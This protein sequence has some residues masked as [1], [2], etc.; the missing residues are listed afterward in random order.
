MLTQDE[1]LFTGVGAGSDCVCTV[2]GRHP[3]CMY[4]HHSLNLEKDRSYHGYVQQ[5]IFV[6]SL[7]VADS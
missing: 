6:Y 4:D 2:Y 7:L 1:N 3:T 5:S